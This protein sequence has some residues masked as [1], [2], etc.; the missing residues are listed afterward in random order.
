MGSKVTFFVGA[1][2][3]AVNLAALAADGS[4]GPSAE[5]RCLVGAPD[6][7]GLHSPG[8]SPLAS[9]LRRS[10]KLHPRIR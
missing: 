8:T 4:D 5:M 2:T 3:L 1:V 7:D 9:F 10:A 6:R